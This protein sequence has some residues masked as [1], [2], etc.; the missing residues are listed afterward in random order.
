MSRPAGDVSRRLEGSKP[1]ADDTSQP[2]PTKSKVTTVEAKVVSEDRPTRSSCKR[3]TAAEWLLHV[4]KCQHQLRLEEKRKQY[5]KKKDGT[6]IGAL[7]KKKLVCYGV[8]EAAYTGMP[9]MVF[10]TVVNTLAK[11]YCRV[12]FENGFMLSLFHTKFMFITNKP[13]K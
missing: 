4:S 6:R 12:K 2:T 8:G 3:V 1:S 13:K 7:V 10:G 5:E 9:K 11:G